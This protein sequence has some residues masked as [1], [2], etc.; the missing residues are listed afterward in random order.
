MV[1]RVSADRIL[2]SFSLCTATF[3]FYLMPTLAITGE[4][5]DDAHPARGARK[6]VF[7]VAVSQYE[8]NLVIVVGFYLLSAQWTHQDLLC[9]HHRAFAVMKRDH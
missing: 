7:G 5:H 8:I 3:F 1:G 9:L 4:L 6:H 2:D